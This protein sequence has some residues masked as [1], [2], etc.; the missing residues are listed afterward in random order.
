MSVSAL[1]DR[2]TSDFVIRP[3]SQ[4]GP[5]YAD[6]LS[7]EHAAH[8]EAVVADVA[9]AAAFA[10]ALA[11]AYLYFARPRVAPGRGVPFPAL[12]VAPARGGGGVS[13][14]GAF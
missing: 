14:L 11:T 9:F 1:N 2:V 13:L 4:G 7:Q 12:L 3:A 10:S 8:S 6:A 5:T